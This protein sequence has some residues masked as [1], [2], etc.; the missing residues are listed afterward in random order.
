MGLKE[1]SVFPVNLF[2][3]CDE[4]RIT[5]IHGKQVIKCP[6]CGKTTVVLIEI[7]SKGEVGS[8]KVREAYG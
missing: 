5:A 3:G 7:N 6:Q 1:G 2:C 8:M 4:R